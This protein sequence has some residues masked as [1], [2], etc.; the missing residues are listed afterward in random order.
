MVTS[1]TGDDEVARLGRAC[2]RRRDDLKQH[3][4][5]LQATTAVNERIAG[6]LQIARS[7]QLSLVP[8]TFPPFPEREESELY[9]LLDAARTIGGDF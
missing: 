7:I 5:E 3:L 4:V 2:A 9:A 8:K 6:E 1:V